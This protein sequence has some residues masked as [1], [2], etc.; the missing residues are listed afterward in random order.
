M[1]W[2]YCQYTIFRVSADFSWIGNGMGVLSVCHFQSECRLYIN[3][4]RHGCIANLP[5]LE[6]ERWL[7]MNWQRDECIVNLPFS[8]RVQWLCM[9]FVLCTPWF[10]GTSIQWRKQLVPMV[11]GLEGS[12]AVQA[13]HKVQQR[14]LLVAW[15]KGVVTSTS[16]LWLFPQNS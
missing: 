12:P 14:K 10:A 5:F 16:V 1:A 13:Q 7:Y 4:Q 15:I 6:W 2:V 11:S 8:E 9:N 3:W